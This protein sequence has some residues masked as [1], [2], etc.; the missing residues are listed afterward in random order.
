MLEGASEEK[1]RGRVNQTFE[2]S[3]LSV[4]RIEIAFI[5]A[6]DDTGERMREND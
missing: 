5:C 1:R 2:K 6:I 4:R 3:T